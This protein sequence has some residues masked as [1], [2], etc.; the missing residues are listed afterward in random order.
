M[1]VWY[2][3]DCISVTNAIRGEGGD[4]TSVTCDIPDESFLCYGETT[5]TALDAVKAGS[6]NHDKV[7]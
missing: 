2:R 5:M 3:F 4:R 7:A 6:Q 1:T